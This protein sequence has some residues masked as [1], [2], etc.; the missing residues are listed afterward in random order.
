MTRVAELVERL[1]SRTDATGSPLPWAITRSYCAPREGYCIWAGEKS[2]FR[3]RFHDAIDAAMA[4][5]EAG[6]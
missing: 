5:M 3:P 1:D 6:A 4:F 2:F